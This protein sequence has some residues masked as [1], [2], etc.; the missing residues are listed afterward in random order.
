M[1]GMRRYT[2]KALGFDFSFVGQA[3]SSSSSYPE[4]SRR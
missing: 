1:N 2:T 3:D 4:S